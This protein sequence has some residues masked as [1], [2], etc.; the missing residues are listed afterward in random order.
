VTV[1]R[2]KG[3]AVVDERLIDWTEKPRGTDRHLKN[4]TLSIPNPDRISHL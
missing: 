1:G 3:C 2:P 4:E